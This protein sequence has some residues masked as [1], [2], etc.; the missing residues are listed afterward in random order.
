MVQKVRSFWRNASHRSSFEDGMND[1][2]RFHLE[3]RT[4]DLVRRGLSPGEAARQARLEFGPI[5]KQKDLARA[6]LG[7]RL[8]DELTGDVRY[9]LRTFR[10]NKA[11][12][13]AAVIT[14]A[15]GIGANTAIFSLIDALM[16][17][18]LPVHR[19][20]D[21]VQLNLAGEAGEAPFPTFSYP[22]VQAFDRQ[23]DLFDGVTGYG[24]SGAVVV[25]PAGALSRVSGAFVTGAFYETLGLTPA[26]GRLIARDDDQPGAPPVAV[27]SYGYWERQFA[28]NPQAIG[29]TLLVNGAPATI[30]GV[31][32]PGFVGANVGQTA[33]ITLPAVMTHDP[34]LLEDGKG[35]FW[36]RTLARPKAGVSVGEAAVRLNAAWQQIGG[37]VIAPHWSA[38]RRKELANARLV[39]TPGATGWSF[40]RD[41]YTKPLWV[42]MAAV[43]L[44]LLIA[45]ANVASLLLARAS[46]RQRE[47]AIRLAIG[48]RRGRIMRQLLVESA[49]LSLT[50]AGCGLI[51]ALFSGRVL[52]D[53][54]STG[55]FRVVF[56]LTPNGHVLAFTTGVAMFTALLFGLAPA[57]QSTA[58]NPTASLKEDA[59]TATGVSRWLP[60]LVTLQVAL[61]LVLLMGAGLFVGT[62]RNLRNLDPGFRTEGVLLAELD[63]PPAAASQLL[64]EIRR[65]PGVVAA[66][67]ST[68]T[69]LSGARWSE[70]AVPAGRPLPERDTAIFVGAGPQFFDTL[71]ISLAAGRAFTDGDVAGGPPVAIVNERY[72]QRFF[73]GKYPLGQHLTSRLNGEA[74]DLEIVGVARNT[75]AIGLRGTAPAVIYIP[76]AQ[77]PKN[78]LATVT[79]RASGGPGDVAAA[80]RRILQ[81]VMPKTPVV[82]RPLSAQ[83]Q[84]TMLQERLM[85]T[86]A[87]ALGALALVLAS[88]GIYGL[89]AYSVARR[90]R[91]IGV[92]MALGA[93][94]RRVVT[95]ILTGVRRP[96]MIGVLVGLPATWAAA[97]SVQSMLFGLEPGDPRAI[98]GA[99]AVLTGV[100]HAAAYLPA[101]RAARV[102]PLVALRHE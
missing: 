37:S 75:N 20:Q 84:A 46:S 56:D 93:E 96:V 47:I 42:L 98:L 70:P 10:R 54:L 40:L 99:I 57:L 80:M 29:Q 6:S 61:S 66:S 34:S 4:A 55:A 71:K 25:G 13:A 11:F 67:F 60:S 5:E 91:E 86:L 97:Q 7:L 41:I 21:L 76:Y 36:L 2:M 14:L 31:S 87:G 88:V 50:G 48:A 68:H 92:R 30:I 63:A 83:L 28:R 81:P 27:L 90:T 17:R 8:L 101:R 49:L 58:L 53:M 15:L 32:P 45:C 44:V 3:S 39:L 72:V 102:D 73:A 51:L 9:A 95:M 100:A 12:T 62:L 74:R 19:P 43:G 1:E 65:V 79:V 94:R 26:A 89:L 22:M 24:G 52:L 23:R 33:D 85:A 82:V 18:S 16:L 35:N 59:R 69:P 64:E 38:A 77:V 78:H